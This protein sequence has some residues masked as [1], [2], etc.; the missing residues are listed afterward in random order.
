MAGAVGPGAR[1]LTFSFSVP[2][3]TT[4]AVAFS[5]FGTDIT[6]FRPF[7]D[8]PFKTSWYSGRMQAFALG[9]E[10]GEHL[11]PRLSENYRRWKVRK[12][13]VAG[14]LVRSGRL[15]ASLTSPNAPGAIWQSGRRSL[16]VG[17]RVRSRDGFGYPQAHQRGTRRMPARPPMHISRL[18]FD[19]VTKDLQRF[20]VDAW[21]TRRTITP[22]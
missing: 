19:A 20:V 8:G 5:R 2:G 15:Q 12:F 14:P 11:W 21:K 16:E 9:G 7:W 3:A 1:G 4:L 13:P 17:S 10:P 22:S 6:D 18:M